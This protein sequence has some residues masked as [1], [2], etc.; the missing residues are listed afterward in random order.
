MLSAQN[1]DAN[2]SASHSSVSINSEAAPL[3]HM[4]DKGQPSTTST[5]SLRTQYPKKRLRVAQQKQQQQQSTSSKPTPPPKATKTTKDRPPQ[6][7]EDTEDSDPPEKRMSQSDL[8]KLRNRQAQRLHRERVLN[9]I[10]ALEG[11]VESLQTRVKHL[12]SENEE[13]KVKLAEALNNRMVV[14]EERE[15]VYPTPKT[16]LTDPTSSSNCSTSVT[17]TSHNS[18]NESL[19][20]KSQEPNSASPISTSSAIPSFASLQRGQPA[21]SSLFYA[22]VQPLTSYTPAYTP[23]QPYHPSSSEQQHG[24][25]YSRHSSSHGSNPNIPRHNSTTENGGVYYR[26]DPEGS[27]Y[28]HTSAYPPAPSTSYTYTPQPPPPPSSAGSHNYYQQHHHHHQ[29]TYHQPSPYPSLTPSS[30][31]YHGEYPRSGYST[32]TTAS[33]PPPP[34]VPQGPQQ[35]HVSSSPAPLQQNGNAR[36]SGSPSVLNGKRKGWEGEGV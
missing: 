17:S 6:K 5:E 8:I 22:P 27:A 36:R 16:A 31:G 10:K 26:H 32:Y 21:S 23:Q 19:R 4:S 35:Q 3:R 25:D 12:E 11:E 30:H 9:K 33:P 15:E 34:L 13:L 20:N 28:P 24:Y 14:D 18:T 1:M 7:D 2:I 29:N